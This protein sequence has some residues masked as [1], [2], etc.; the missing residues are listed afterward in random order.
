MKLRLHMIGIGGIGMS[1]L[2]QILLARGFEVSG[3]DVQASEMTA[4]LAAQGARVS[5]GHRAE[6]VAGSARVVISDAIHSDNPELRRARELELP[7]QRRS[8]LL[9]ELMAGCRGIAVSGTHGKTTVTA[10]IGAILAEGGLD[11]SVVLGGEFA[12]LGGN[13]RVGRG[14]WFVTEACEAYESF[15]DLRPEIAVVTN[16][17]ADHLDHHKTERHLR[18]SFVQFLEGVAPEGSIVMCADRRELAD[19]PLP[20]GRRVIWYGSEERAEVR[21]TDIG[22]A[23]REGRCNLVLGGEA[24][25]VVRVASPGVHNV[26]NALGATAAALAAGAEV[27]AC[28]E[29]L[30]AFTG[31]GRRFE[32]VGEPS[33]ITIV[34]DYAHHPTE[35]AATIAAARAAYPGRRIVALFQPHLYSRTRDFAGQFAEA[36]READLTVLTEIYAAREAPLPGV[37]SGLIADRLRPLVGEDGVLEVAKEEVAAELPAQ[38]RSGD[39]VLSMGAG[40]IGRTAR[41]LVR[42]LG[43]SLR[44]DQQVVAKQ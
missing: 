42:R 38:L 34:D 26:M 24:A 6:N 28:R 31:V 20:P 35:I 1:A 39:V 4:R 19:L 29:A 37:T 43:G 12:P 8:E 7:V 5:I 33:G 13:A 44:I 23:G 36:L 25:G 22:T 15:L 40:D 9:A 16:I 10:M 14:D 3:S 41:E 2:A 27:S 21:G 11:P 18:G 17:E 32:V 30:K